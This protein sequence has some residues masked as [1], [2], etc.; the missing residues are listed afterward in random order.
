M[1]EGQVT[2]ISWVVVSQRRMTNV[3]EYSCLIDGRSHAIAFS[4]PKK[5]NDVGVWILDA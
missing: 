1:L 2:A 4:Q 3:N 5:I